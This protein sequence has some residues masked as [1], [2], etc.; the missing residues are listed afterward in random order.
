VLLEAAVE[1]GAELRERFVVEEVLGDGDRVTG[2]RGRSIGGGTVTERA[3]VTIGADGMRSI[4]ARTVDSPIYHSDPTVTCWYHSY[5]SGVPVEM[6]EIYLLE[7]RD[8]IAHPTND[9]LTC[10]IVGWPL[11][12]FDAVRH[13]VEGSFMAIRGDDYQISRYM[14][15]VANTIPF[16]DFFGR[17]NM[18]RLVGRPG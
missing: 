14:G 11:Y 16:N 1:A 9:G 3:H 2:I 4:V 17:E 18:A 15:A 7:R 13:D 12:A 10:V 6:I 8:V 5:W